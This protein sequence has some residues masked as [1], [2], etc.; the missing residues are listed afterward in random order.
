MAR[1]NYLANQLN[2]MGFSFQSVR[3]PGGSLTGTVSDV[4]S[5]ALDFQ[6]GQAQSAAADA[7]THSDAMNALD[8]R[9]T[10]EYGVDV[11]DEMAKLLQLQAAYSANARVVTVA[12][13]LV[14]ALM[15]AVTS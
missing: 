6:G 4:I 8:T 3:P 10:S 11:N 2:T 14:N 9:M 15:Q 7:S 1:V 13:N 12:Q 5:H